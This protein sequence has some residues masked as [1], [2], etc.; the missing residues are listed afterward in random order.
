MPHIT[1]NH[2]VW[3]KSSY[4]NCHFTD[5]LPHSFSFYFLLSFIQLCKHSIHSHPKQKKKKKHEHTISNKNR[6][7]DDKNISSLFIFGFVIRMCYANGMF[8]FLDSPKSMTFKRKLS[9]K[10]SVNGLHRLQSFINIFLFLRI[11]K[12]N[13]NISFCKKN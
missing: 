10:S 11:L 5:I 8:S 1:I 13:Q 9:L 2:T 6:G 12:Q 7:N 4:L 3:R